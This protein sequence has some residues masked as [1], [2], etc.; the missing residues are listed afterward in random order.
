M[1]SCNGN[2][3][4]ASTNN[5]SRDSMSSATTTES[6]SPSTIVTSPQSMFVVVHK[7]SNYTKWKASYDGHDSMRVAH[8][9]HNY[10]IGRGIEDSNTVLVAVKTDDMNKAKA[11]AKDPSLK[12]AMQ[13]G[14]VIGTPKFAFTTMTFQDTAV[15]N[16][17]LRARVTF[18]VK[19]WDAWL[20]GFEDGKQERLDNG[21]IVRAVGHDADDNKQVTVVT[22]VSDSA[23]A[24]AYVK[25]DMMKK[26]REASG[27]IGEPERFIY[28]VVQR[29]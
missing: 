8:G 16:S 20:K 27:V 19:D 24:A 22:A 29:Y 21:I 26:R 23:K 25:S 4:N 13:K 1:L 3:D 15:I 12:A 9:M 17:P 10:V 6:T 28:R 18:T 11:F 7:V 14:G 2:K 5:S